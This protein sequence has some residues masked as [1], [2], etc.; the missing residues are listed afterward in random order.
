MGSNMESLG[1]VA[2]WICEGPTRHKRHRLCHK[3]DRTRT[4]QPQPK[5]NELIS[6]QTTYQKKN[7]WESDGSRWKMGNK[8]RRGSLPTESTATAVQ[9]KHSRKPKTHSIR[10]MSKDSEEDEASLPERF[11]SNNSMQTLKSHGSK[12]TF[13]V[14]AEEAMV[15]QSTDNT[16]NC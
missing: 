16:I 8:P 6:T 2:I 13:T 9:S 7:G 4:R 10:S 3:F 15:P 5:E 1:S 14:E 12:E 11:I